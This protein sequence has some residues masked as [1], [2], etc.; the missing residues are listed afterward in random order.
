MILEQRKRGS[1]IIVD[2]I[3]EIKKPQGSNEL[4]VLLKQLLEKGNK[5]IGLNM[6]QVTYLDSGAISSI[7]TTYKKL[8][9]K[10]EMFIVE[11]SPDVIDIITLLELNSIINIYRSEEELDHHLKSQ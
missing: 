8:K 10:G 7:I 5:R 2:I 6:S 9:K 1:A 11:P 3:G 4:D